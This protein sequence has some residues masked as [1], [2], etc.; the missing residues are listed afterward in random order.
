MNDPGRFGRLTVEGND[1][2]ETIL[3]LLISKMPKRET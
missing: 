2:T 1:S 3:L